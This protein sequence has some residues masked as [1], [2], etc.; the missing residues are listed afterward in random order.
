MTL[1]MT[2]KELRRRTGQP[3]TRWERELAG[4]S[5]PG[6]GSLKG[7]PCDIQWW[8]DLEKKYQVTRDSTKH[9]GT[10]TFGFFRSD[11]PMD[12]EIIASNKTNQLFAPDDL[13]EQ[14][15]SCMCTD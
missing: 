11:G 3:F 5:W 8:I 10:V 13:P 12:Y 7:T 4:E 9:K 6:F 14:S 15:I 2:L 1:I